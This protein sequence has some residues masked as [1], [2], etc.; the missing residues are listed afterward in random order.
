MNWTP[1][2]MLLLAIPLA[3]EANA[4]SSNTWASAEALLWWIKDGP[5]P[6]PLATT[7]P[8]NSPSPIPGAL[9]AADSRVVLGG[10]EID[11]TTQL[12]GRFTIG[13]WLANAPSLGVEANYLFLGKRSDSST[14]ASDGSQF[15]TN[16][17][18]EAAAGQFVPLANYL[19]T[20]GPLNNGSAT[21]TT[22]HELQSAEL[23]VLI[24]RIEDNRRSWSLLAG[25]RYLSVDEGLTLSTTQND[26]VNFF[27][28]Q[29]VNTLD[30]FETRNDF[31]GGQFGIR[32]Q[33]TRGIWFF[34]STVKVALGNMHEVVR[35]RG[36][37]VTNTGAGFLTQIPVTTAPGGVY[38][39]PTNI[40]NYERDHFAVLPEV[41]LRFG[42]QIT[43]HAR[44]FVGYDFLLSSSIRL[45]ASRHL[46]PPLASV[47][48]SRLGPHSCEALLRLGATR[49][50]CPA[51]VARDFRRLKAV[52]RRV[53]PGRL[54]DR[55]P[56]GDLSP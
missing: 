54:G 32:G 46:I 28:G 41:T 16:P 37:S 1:A 5:A 52:A 29:F 50:A 38:A 3:G 39:Q 48:S 26:D 24:L 22:S 49:R 2:L 13:R 19:A 30:Q 55:R 27:P 42:L 43:Q 25:Y 4:Q 10:T 45:P 11:H 31:H 35:I 23:N 8:A 14:V 20:A 18:I 7:A 12:G 33:W 15:L 47:P 21:L 51:V 56:T 17:F 6:I 40:G 36:D 34:G 44:A 9:N 53:G